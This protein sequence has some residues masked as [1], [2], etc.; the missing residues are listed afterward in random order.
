MKITTIKVFTLSIA[1]SACQSLKDQVELPLNLGTNRA[2]LPFKA[3][4]KTH[5]GTATLERRVGIGTELE[6]IL[7]EGTILFQLDNCAR[8]HVAI[9][10]DGDTYT[11]RF[12]PSAFKEAEDSCV[13][14]AQATTYRGEMQ[15]AIIDWTDRRTLKARMWCNE[16][17]ATPHEGVALCQ[18]RRS[19]LMWIEFDEEVVWAGS[20]SC[21]K[22]VIARDG[23]FEIEVGEG[24]CAYQFMSKSRERFRLTT[25]GYTT[26]REVNIEAERISQ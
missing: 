12:N 22:P 6:F 3:E 2:S 8:E 11:Y 7:P 15:T 10:P 1:F 14:N 4:G 23:S 13:M 20:E 18:N 21:P 19:K 26:I 24:F 5:I 25:Y 16:S 9:R 17:Q